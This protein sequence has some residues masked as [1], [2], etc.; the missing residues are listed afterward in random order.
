MKIKLWKYFLKQRNSTLEPT[1]DWEHIELEGYLNDSCSVLNPVINFEYNGTDIQTYNYAYVEEYKR[2]YFIDNWTTNYNLWAA[3]MSVDVMGTYK[4]DLLG[5]KQYVTRNQSTFKGGIIDNMYTVYTDPTV[6]QIA[7]VENKVI[8]GGEGGNTYLT[9]TLAESDFNDGYVAIGVTG[10]L[11]ESTGVSYYLLPCTIGGFGAFITKLYQIIP[12]EFGDIGSGLAKQLANP[13]QYITS[14]YWYP[15]LPYANVTFEYGRIQLGF[16]NV[17]DVNRA[18]VDPKVVAQC[19]NVFRFEASEHP[20]VTDYGTYLNFAPYSQYTLCYLPFGVIELDPA[21]FMPGQHIR[22]HFMNDITNG[23]CT[24][25]VYGCSKYDSYDY[26]NVVYKGV[27]NTGVE[28]PVMQRTTDTIGTAGSVLGAI[29]S[30]IMGNFA[31]AASSIGNAINSATPDYSQKGSVGGAI[32]WDRNPCLQIKRFRPVGNAPQIYGKPLCQ[33][34][35]LDTLTGFTK[36]ENA[37]IADFLKD[38][39]G[40][41]ITEYEEVINYLNNG[42]YIE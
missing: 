34:V 15:F 27:C 7:P 10:T 41:L 3:S 32:G 12:T 19:E 24:F 23:R 4:Y 17:N 18:K 25:V 22:V 2:Y 38:G 37:I 1:D 5:S 8:I 9:G 11:D 36:C 33:Y 40:A 21:L 31:G 16:Y 35:K 20:D 6:E 14:C 42:F 26:V 29:G 39:Q 30:A 28:L 13:I